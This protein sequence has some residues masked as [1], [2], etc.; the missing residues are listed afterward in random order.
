[1]FYPKSVAVGSR[2]PAKV[3]AVEKALREVNLQAKVISVE[4]DTSVGPQ[5]IGLEEILIGAIER[6][7]KAVEKAD[8]GVGIEAGL[9][10]VQATITGYV[11]FQVAAIV[12][13]EYKLSIG[14]SPGFEFPEKAV[15]N[16]VTGKVS[17][18]EEIMVEITD[19]ENIGD[20]MGAVGF[21][22]RGIIV[23]EE[24]SRLAFLMALIPR[25]N[26]ELYKSYPNALEALKRF[27]TTG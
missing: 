6:G 23:R 13:R 4:C 8:W 12:D 1:M 14:F 9:V 19:V 2:N 25:L 22:T 16:V 17:E 24:L 3:K 26:P 7:L 15:N 27:K 5:P 18:L 10:P 20:K 21:L 11:D